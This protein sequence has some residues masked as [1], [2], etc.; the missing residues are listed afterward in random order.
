MHFERPWTCLS[1][2]LCPVPASV[3]SA[4]AEQTVHPVK[5]CVFLKFF[6]VIFPPLLL[7]VVVLSSPHPPPPPRSS[8][9]P[10][11]LLLPSPFFFLWSTC[12]RRSV[13]IAFRHLP[14]P[15]FF[16]LFS[17]S[18][19]FFLR[20]RLC[21]HRSATSS[22]CLVTVASFPSARFAPSPR[23]TAPLPLLSLYRLR[24]LLLPL[25]SLAAFAP[26]QDNPRRDRGV[27]SR[28][29]HLKVNG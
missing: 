8:S 3:S 24:F 27:T 17:C 18:S 6:F 26:G 2:A 19:S 25:C 14:P 28:Q 9:S 15:A 12:R 22:P 29:Q 11:L 5:G 16:G 13:P 21:P 1:R 20:L 10:L 7:F 4:I 23:S